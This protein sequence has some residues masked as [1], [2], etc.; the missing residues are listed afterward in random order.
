MRNKLFIASLFTASILLTGCWTGT[1]DDEVQC[2]YCDSTGCYDENCEPAWC[3]VDEDCWEGEYCNQSY[4][5][6]FPSDIGCYYD[7]ECPNGMIC[8]IYED[9]WDYYGY[10]VNPNQNN[11][12]HN[13]WE[14]PEDAY[15]DEMTGRCLPTSECATSTD[16]QEGYYCDSRHVCSPRPAGDCTSD[17]QCGIGAYCDDGTCVNSNLCTGNDQCLDP[18]APICDERGVCVPDTN[19]VVTCSVNTDCDAGKIC[20]DGVCEN[21]TPRDP[22]LNCLINEHCGQN[23]VCINGECHAPCVDSDDCGTAQVCGTS[24]ICVDDPNPGTE[25]TI[26]TDC[27]DSTDICINGVC[28]DSCTVN[29]DCSNSNDRCDDGVCVPNDVARPMCYTNNDCNGGEE[30][31]DGVCRVPCTDADDCVACPG[32]PICGA[33]GFCVDNNDV[34]PEC[35]LNSECSSTEVCMDAMCVEQ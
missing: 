10:C 8:E 19:P 24:G 26:N 29:S 9:G 25:C 5:Q 15:C 32:N 31:V 4:N 6:C 11:T 30:C 17:D 18:A 35:S 21:E 12:C 2:N 13:D 34:N 27:V 7:W 1:C 33:G 23:G 20:V 14:C 3:W 16:C 28:H 22:G